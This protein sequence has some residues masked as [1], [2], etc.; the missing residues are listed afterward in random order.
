M[1]T[2]VKL[3]GGYIHSRVLAPL[4]SFQKIQAIENAHRL[5]RSFWVKNNEK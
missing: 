3:L 2:I 4:I 5:I 1:Q